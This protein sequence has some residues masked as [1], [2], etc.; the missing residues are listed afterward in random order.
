MNNR[1]DPTTGFAMLIFGGVMLTVFAVAA[2][3]LFLSDNQ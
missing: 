1:L 2:R 3:I